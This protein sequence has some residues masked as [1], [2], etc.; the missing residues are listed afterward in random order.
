MQLFNERRQ[1]IQQDKVYMLVSRSMNTGG[2]SIMN[3]SSTSNMQPDQMIPRDRHSGPNLGIVVTIYVVLFLVGLSFVTVFVTRPSFPSPNASITSIVTYFQV[4][5]AQVRISAF[6]SF[7][8]IIMLGI[9]TACIVNRFRALGMRS[10]WVDIIFFAG[11]ATAFDQGMSHLCEW[12]L[13]WPGIAQNTPT[14]LAIYYLLYGLGG[15]GFSVPMG[16][17]VGSISLI[18][19]RMK[20]LLTWI[21]WSGFVISAIGIV[22]WLNFLL[23]TVSILP[24]TIPFTR[25]P[26]FIWLIAMAFTLPKTLAASAPSQ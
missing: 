11:L 14:T 9:F 20:L 10:V 3:M 18:G 6:I 22:S 8:S 26:S 15:P 17:F 23:P 21:V 5:P 12:A 7:G 2:R 13:T 16:I 4:R 24:L 1:V 19:S 25:F